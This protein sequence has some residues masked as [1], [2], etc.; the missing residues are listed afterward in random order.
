MIPRVGFTPR[1][2][3]SQRPLRK[4]VENTN[5]KADAQLVF[6]RSL[7]FLR[8][9]R[10]IRLSRHLVFGLCVLAVFDTRRR[11]GSTQRPQSSQRPQRGLKGRCIAN[12]NAHFVFLRSLWFLRP[13][14]EMKLCELGL[15]ANRISYFVISTNP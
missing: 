4:L 12:A 13:L 9:L 10:E 1:P 2:Q 7:R 6:L 14:R 8:P 5:A 15:T 11:V 3:S